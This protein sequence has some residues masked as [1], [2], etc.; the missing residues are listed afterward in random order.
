M[1]RARLGDILY[2]YSAD[3]K[4]NQERVRNFTSFQEIFTKYCSTVTVTAHSHLLSFTTYISVERGGETLQAVNISIEFDVQ[5]LYQCGLQPLSRIGSV[6]CSKICQAE[7]WWKVEQEEERGVTRYQT[8]GV[9][10]ARNGPH[11]PSTPGFPSA[12]AKQKVGPSLFTFICFK[13]P[14]SPYS[15]ELPLMH[16][17]SGNIHGRTVKQRMTCQRNICLWCNSWT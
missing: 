7:E 6:K 17:T 13:H 8:R 11:I 15:P 9:N 10:K 3:F 2:A 5:R 12:T 4:G 14:H 1:L 16:W